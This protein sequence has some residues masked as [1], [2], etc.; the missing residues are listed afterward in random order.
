MKKYFLDSNIFLR[1][2][3][4]DNKE[5]FTDCLVLLEKINLGQIRAYTSN[6]VLAEIVWTL[7]SGYK[8][9]KTKIHEAVTSIINVSSLKIDDDCDSSH[10]LEFYVSKSVKYIDALIA[11]NPEIQAKKM[12]I[13][14]YDKDFDKLGVKRLEPQDLL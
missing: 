5:M 13:V 3:T 7:S 4:Q 14:S 1:I 9:S 10:A 11:S 8:F 12:T 2:F 6:F